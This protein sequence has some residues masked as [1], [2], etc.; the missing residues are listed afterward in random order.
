MEQSAPVQLASQMQVPESVLKVPWL[1]HCSGQV[2]FKISQLIPPQPGL[3]WQSPWWQAPWPEHVGS[4]QSTEDT[5]WG[6]QRCQFTTSKQDIKPA[7]LLRPLS[8]SLPPKVFARVEVFQ[9]QM[10]AGEPQLKLLQCLAV[11]GSNFPPY[12]QLAPLQYIIGYFQYTDSIIMLH[13]RH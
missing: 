13:Y 11:A 9:R 7:Y 12:V 8:L 2:L 4:T 1:E 10:M 5:Q 6:R 3:Q